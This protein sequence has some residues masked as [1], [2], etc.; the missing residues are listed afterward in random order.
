MKVFIAIFALLAV[1]M[2]AEL[3][4]VSLNRKFLSLQTSFHYEDP[5]QT[6]HK[7]VCNGEGET[8][9]QILGIGAYYMCNPETIGANYDCYFDFPPGNTAK[10]KAIFTDNHGVIR[11]AL[12]CHGPVVGNCSGRAECMIIP[13]DSDQ[14][15]FC[16][17]KHI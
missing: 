17:Y 4:T 5:F 2:C 11:C 1:A 9:N 10:P 14:T 12:V 13:G 3:G 8:A 16:A 6:S 7:P 15:G